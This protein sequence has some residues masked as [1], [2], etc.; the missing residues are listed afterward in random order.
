MARDE[1]PKGEPMKY[2]EEVLRAAARLHIRPEAVQTYLDAGEGKRAP[3]R[4]ADDAH[5]D[6]AGGLGL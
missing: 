3:G 2:S 4:R 6:Q 1:E 5:H